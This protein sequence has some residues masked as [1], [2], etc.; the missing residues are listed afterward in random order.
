M[1][2][3]DR[4]L[5]QA[6]TAHAPLTLIVHEDDMACRVA[7][8]PRCIYCAS[9]L[10]F[11]FS[12]FHYH[13]AHGGI[14]RYDALPNVRVVPSSSQLLKQAMAFFPRLVLYRSL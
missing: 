5:W 10:R 11:I 4:Y 14:T 8:A 13:I 6:A 1:T 7:L 2:P 9:L 3:M 12:I